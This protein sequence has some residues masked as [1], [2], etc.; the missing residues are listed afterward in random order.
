VSKFLQNL[1][2]QISKALVNSKKSNF[3]FEKFFSLYFGPAAPPAYP[4]FW[5]S[6]P[7]WPNHPID[8][9]TL[10]AHLAHPASSSS[11]STEAEQAPPPS[12]FHHLPAPPWHLPPWS[13]YPKLCTASIDRSPLL[14]SSFHGLNLI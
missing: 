6:W 2:V 7:Y 5:P 9:F 1:L 14:P 10:L 8:L 13:H 12:A 3:Y 11:F 4:A